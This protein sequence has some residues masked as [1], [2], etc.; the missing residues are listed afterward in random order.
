MSA[1][2]QRDDTPARATGAQAQSVPSRAP[3]M[4]EATRFKRKSL[5]GTKKGKAHAL[6][7]RLCR[8]QVRHEGTDLP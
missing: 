7:K 2:A 6:C 3:R 8:G 1:R 5:A 4:R